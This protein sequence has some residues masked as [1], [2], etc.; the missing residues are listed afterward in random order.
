MQIRLKKIHQKQYSIK[1]SLVLKSVMNISYLYLVFPLLLLINCSSKNNEQSIEQEAPEPILSEELSCVEDSF[2]WSDYRIEIEKKKESYPSTK[3]KIITSK[4][5]LIQAYQEGSI[6][7]DS[8][9]NYFTETILNHIFPYWYGTEWDFEGHTNTP[10]DGYVACGYFVSTTLKH[11]GVNVNRYKLAQQSALNAIKTLADGDTI[12]KLH[13]TLEVDISERIKAELTEGLYVV[14]LSCH[15]GF[16]LVRNGEA[17]FIHSDYTAPAE[18]KIEL[19]HESTAF[20]YSNVYFL[21][22]ISNNDQLLQKW[23][24]GE[25]ID[26]ISS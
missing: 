19:L 16:V 24:K 10:N 25:V 17:F 15:V 9:S 6:G 13:E 23:L 2:D 7:L 8:V 26:I 1:T 18:A 21:C 3:Q 5:G 12:Y 4:G 14:G 22:R 20:Y 11:M